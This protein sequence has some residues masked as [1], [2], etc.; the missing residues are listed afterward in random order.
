LLEESKENIIKDELDNLIPEED[1][2]N[3]DSNVNNDEEQQE[4]TVDIPSLEFENVPNNIQ[5]DRLDRMD[6][7]DR[8]DKE[9]NSSSLRE[10]RN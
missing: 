4:D 5:K 10:T 7:H 3:N 2:N 6:K 8:Q 1:E 9:T